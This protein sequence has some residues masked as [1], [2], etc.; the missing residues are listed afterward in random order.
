VTQ[1]RAT[2]DVLAAVAFLRRD[3]P[4]LPTALVGHSMGAVFTV[5]ALAADPTIRA[6]VLAAP[7][8]TVRAEITSIE[9]AGYRGLHAVS[10]LTS[11]TPL[12]PVR[13]PYKYDYGRLFADPEA[14]E[15]ARQSG[16]L[17]RTV[18]LSNVPAFLAMDASRDAARVRQPVLV[19]LATHDRAVRRASSMAVF[20]ALAGPK[21]LAEIDSG[22]SMWTDRSAAKAIDLVDA[23]LQAQLS[24][25]RRAPA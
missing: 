12:G 9:Y 7:M 23:W 5:R 3:G 17:V 20:G 13:V 4:A 15:R 24:P 21:E 2:A 11:R 8:R 1:E 18:D 22:H 25:E 19:I 6:A 14:A 10:R 16:F